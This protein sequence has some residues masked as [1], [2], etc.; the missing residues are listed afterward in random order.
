MYRVHHHVGAVRRARGSLEHGQLPD[1]AVDDLVAGAEETIGTDGLL[2][3]WALVAAFLRARL[4]EHADELDCDCGSDAWLRRVQPDNAGGAEG[5][6]RR[7][8]GPSV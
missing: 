1:P 5:G 4:Q 8:R 3:G 2:S 7:G 6:D